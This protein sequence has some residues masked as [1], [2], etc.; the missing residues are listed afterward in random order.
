MTNHQVIFVRVL[1]ILGLSCNLVSTLST[2]TRE[3]LLVNTNSI[4]LSRIY[5]LYAFLQRLEGWNA[6]FIRLYLTPPQFFLKRMKSLDLLK[7]TVDQ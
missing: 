3:S 6:L 4:F 7:K 2:Y 5:L 1:L